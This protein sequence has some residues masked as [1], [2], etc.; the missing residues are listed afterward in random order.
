MMKYSCFITCPLLISFLRVGR[1]RLKFL[2]RRVW[3]P[4]RSLPTPEL[5]TCRSPLPPPPLLVTGC[6][7]DPTRDRAQPETPAPLPLHPTPSSYPRHQP[8]MSL[9]C[10]GRLKLLAVSL[11]AVALLTWLYLLA[12]SLE[13]ESE[14]A[15]LSLFCLSSRA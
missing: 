14:H 15:Q 10:R 12:G 7:R 2:M 3:P 1:A 5:S 6:Y 9:L 13:G 11:T 8:T 4:S